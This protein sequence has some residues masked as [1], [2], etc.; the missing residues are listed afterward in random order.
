MTAIL[1]SDH[2]R[3]RGLQNLSYQKNAFY[4]LTFALLFHLSFI[5]T[6][7]FTNSLDGGV[8]P[9]SDSGIIFC[10]LTPFP[11]PI[12]DVATGTGYKVTIPLSK[13]TFGVPIPVPGVEI[14]PEKTIATQ[15]EISQAN[16]SQLR[17]YFG[18]GKEIVSQPIIK[19]ENEAEPP[20]DS[21]IAVEI[22]PQI[23]KQIVPD[24]PDIA[25][26]AGVEGTV[27]VNCL[28]DKNGRVKKAIVMK[29][30]NPIFNESATEAAMQWLFTP[31]IMNDG[32][33]TVWATVPF[34]FQ[35]NK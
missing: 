26:R 34:K 32:P 17:N 7:Y 25:R 2:F 22:R 8:N 19:I 23:V 14:S 16:D 35:L 21:F 31:A 27:W 3:T 20:I 6:Y 29:T 30:D 4:G 28:V 15:R 24:F 10:R 33:V 5:A 11:V 1:N 18:T 13:P 12:T 9:Q